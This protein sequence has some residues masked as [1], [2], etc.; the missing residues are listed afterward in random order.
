MSG[1]GKNAS[2][3]GTRLGSYRSYAFGEEGCG[4]NQSVG[5]GQDETPGVGSMSPHLYKERKCGPAVR[6][7]PLDGQDIMS[8]WPLDCWFFWWL[9]S[10]FLPWELLPGGTRI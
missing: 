7:P 2:E 3:R 10:C 4:A 6:L 1:T 9:P 8:R 5:R